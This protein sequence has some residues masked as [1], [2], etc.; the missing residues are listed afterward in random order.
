MSARKPSRKRPL[1][2]ACYGLF[3]GLSCDCNRMCTLR[4]SV[5]YC[6]TKIGCMGFAYAHECILCMCIYL[7]CVHM[8]VGIQYVCKVCMRRL[9]TCEHVYVRTSM[10]MYLSTCAARKCGLCIYIYICISIGI[11]RMKTCVYIY[12][13]AYATGYEHLFASIRAYVCIHIYRCTCVNGYMYACI[14]VCLHIRTYTCLYVYVYVFVAVCYVRAAV[15]VHVHG[16]STCKL[17]GKYTCLYLYPTVSVDA[18]FITD[19]TH[20][21]IHACKDM[22]PCTYVCTHASMHVCMYVYVCMYV[23]FLYANQKIS[24]CFIRTPRLGLK[25]DRERCSEPWGKAS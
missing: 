22:K 3:L 19:V 16:N 14:C 21:R 13:H 1:L 20:F 6:L 10:Y 23:C 12:V 25:C 8:H 5:S 2:L 24:A 11:W 15:K 4:R 9:C 18:V 17:T 7:A